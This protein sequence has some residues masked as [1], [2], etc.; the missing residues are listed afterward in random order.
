MDAYKR[1]Y[2]EIA[3]EYGWDGDIESVPEFNNQANNTDTGIP[4]PIIMLIVIV[5]FIMM[6]RRWRWWL[7]VVDPADIEE[8]LFSFARIIWRRW[9]I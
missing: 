3:Q 8:A 7:G 1:F 9:R 4:F 5:I 6:G 2:N